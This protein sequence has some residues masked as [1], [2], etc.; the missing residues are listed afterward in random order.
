M[1]S[2]LEQKRLEQKGQLR[3]ELPRLLLAFGQQDDFHEA[4]SD[5]FDDLGNELFGVCAL[6]LEFGRV[7]Q[8]LDLQLRLS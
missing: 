3:E 7:A 1:L 4:D 8:L 6:T 2:P 5:P